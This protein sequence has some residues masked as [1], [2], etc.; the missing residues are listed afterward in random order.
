MNNLRR[1]I[2]QTQFLYVKDLLTKGKETKAKH[3]I[4][5]LPFV[6]RVLLIVQ[7]RSKG[8]KVK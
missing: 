6:D 2:T 3:Y 7:L 8:Y 5:K 4:S 1:L